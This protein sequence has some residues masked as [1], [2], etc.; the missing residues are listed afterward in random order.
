MLVSDRSTWKR[1]ELPHEDGQWVLLRPL[2]ADE[3][4]HCLDVRSSAVLKKFA[5]LPSE[6]LRVFRE[7]TDRTRND[8]VTS[9]E[10]DPI[11]AIKYAVMEWSYG[12]DNCTDENKQNLDMQTVE[13]IK[14]RILEMNAPRPLSSVNGSNSNSNVAVLYPS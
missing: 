4:Q 10:I 11:T 9:R 7:D 12:T 14:D 8:E 1:F 6:T 13:V 3:Y 2:T 5:D